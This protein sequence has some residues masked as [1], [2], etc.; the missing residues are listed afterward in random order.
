MEAINTVD[1][2]YLD[3]DKADELR[4][5]LLKH[6]IVFN[7]RLGT[8]NVSPHEINLVDGFKPKSLKPYRIPEVLKS[9]VGKQIKQLLEDGTIMESSSCFAHPI[10]C[11]AK[12]K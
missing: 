3:K 11:V 4:I 8:C 1:L 7:N 6:R 2:S 10:V 9:E 5:L 12:T